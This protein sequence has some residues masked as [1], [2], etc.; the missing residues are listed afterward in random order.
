[1]TVADVD[2]WHAGMAIL[3][4]RRAG[5]GIL[6]VQYVKLNTVFHMH[7]EYSA[8]PETVSGPI[9]PGANFGPLPAS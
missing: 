7:R 1:M 8:G 5:V 6:C 4:A 3:A 9:F 2:S